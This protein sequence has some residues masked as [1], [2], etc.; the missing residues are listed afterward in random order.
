MTFNSHQTT[1]VLDFIKNR[2]FEEIKDLCSKEHIK[3]KELENEESRNLYLLVLDEDLLLKNSDYFKTL[4]DSIEMH[5][6]Q[7]N[8]A[9]ESGNLELYKTILETLKKE[10]FDLSVYLKQT[11]LTNQM[12]D[13]Q[14]MLNGAIFEKETNQPICM[15]YKRMYDVSSKLNEIEKLRYGDIT[16]DYC[17]DGTVIRL[18]NYDDKWFTATRRCI[19]AKYSYWS[20]LQTFDEMF[21]DVIEDKQLFL[22][23]LD[24]DMTYFFVLK[25]TDNRIVVKNQESSLVYLGSVN[26]VTMEEYDELNYRQHN[27]TKADRVSLNVFDTTQKLNVF[28]LTSQFKNSKKR[29]LIITTKTG[30]KYK[31][32]FDEFTYLKDLRGNTPYIRMRILELLSDKEKLSAFMKNYSEYRMTYSMIVMQLNELVKTI[33]KLY[34]DTHVKRRFIIDSEHPNFKI[35]KQL[36]NKFKETRNPIVYSDVEFILEK[37]QPMYLKTL[38]GWKH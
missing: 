27:I 13:F 31:L 8:N 28:D 15:C 34:I 20:G 30:N 11:K 26:R 19:D 3:V 37:T 16:V 1:L 17:E 23:T 22:S 12:T 35:I 21:W 2:S 7:L 6:T 36:H 33:H 38:L 9:K 5:Q 14:L 18:Y 29:G 24:K 10:R 32:D 25:H 4:N